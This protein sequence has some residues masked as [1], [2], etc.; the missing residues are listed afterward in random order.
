[1]KK[2]NEKRIIKKDLPYFTVRKDIFN[3]LLSA[4]YKYTLAIYILFSDRSKISKFKDEEGKNYF[5]YPIEELK[6]YFNIEKSN[7]T[8]LNSIN[9]LIEKGLIEAKKVNGTATKY[10]LKPV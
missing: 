2:E 4:K 3:K 1:M 9:E 7:K 10:Y 6:K 8:L 5:V